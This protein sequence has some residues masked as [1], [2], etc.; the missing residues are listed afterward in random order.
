MART[1]IGFAVGTCCIILTFAASAVSVPLYGLLADELQIERSLLSFVTVSYFIGTVSSLLFFARL[2]DHLGRRPLV[3]A[4]LVISIIGCLLLAHIASLGMFCAGRFLH[5]IACGIAMGSAG[6]YVLD[7]SENKPAWV[8][9]AVNTSGSQMG[10][11]IGAFIAAGIAGAGLGTALGFYGIAALEALCACALLVAPE[12]IS[13]HPG[14][15]RSVAPKLMMP[16]LVRV[17]LPVCCCAFVCTWGIGGF[18]QTFSF[19]L[20]Q[21]CF[22]DP[23]IFYAALAF[24][25]YML[26]GFPGSVLS[27]RFDA[28]VSQRLGMTF[29]WVAFVLLMIAVH[30]GLG[31]LLIFVCVLGGVAHGMAYSAAL[32][33]AMTYV[34]QEERAGTLSSITLI[35]Y[36]GAM[37]PNLIVG[38][39]GSGADVFTVACGYAVMVAICVVGSFFPSRDPQASG[40]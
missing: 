31:G 4:S 23:S 3:L 17:V 14:A 38:F 20:G 10:F 25:L 29:V 39:A 27:G 32:R 11:A 24:A 8:P 6:S 16:K 36:A 33:R 2:S 21:A 28:L 34:T 1:E 26:S 40:R 30:E 15:L 35:S 5:G 19:S 18:Y 13:G 12:T 37:G 7:N 9:S 22:H